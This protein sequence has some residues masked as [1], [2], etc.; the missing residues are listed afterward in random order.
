MSRMTGPA[1]DACGEMEPEDVATADGI[2]MIVHTLAE[3]CQGESDVDGSHTA[4][5]L[6]AKGGTY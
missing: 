1:W 2:D 5:A 6:H 4:Y 3:A